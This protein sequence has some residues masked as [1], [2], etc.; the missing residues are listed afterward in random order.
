MGAFRACLVVALA[1]TS[2]AAVV[3]SGAATHCVLVATVPAPGAVFYYTTCG[4]YMECNGM[5][6]FQEG[7][8]GVQDDCPV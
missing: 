6:G 1:L 7:V 4:L 8:P 2:L 5:S 3:P